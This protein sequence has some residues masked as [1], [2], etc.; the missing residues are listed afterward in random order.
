MTGQ[1]GDPAGKNSAEWG[2]PP[3]PPAPP[4]PG[5]VGLPEIVQQLRALADGVERGEYGEV[6]LI[7]LVIESPGLS[8][9]PL[10]FGDADPKRQ[11]GV[12]SCGVQELGEYIRFGMPGAAR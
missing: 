5:A 12:L 10:G 7:T 3:P 8:Y 4:G 1:I 9:I 2:A 6:R 11:M